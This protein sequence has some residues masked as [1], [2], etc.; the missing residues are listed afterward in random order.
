MSTKVYLVGDKDAPAK[1]QWQAMT[2]NWA[3]AERL[4]RELGP[5]ATHKVVMVEESRRGNR[6]R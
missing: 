2:N 3:E 1:N 6:K 4:K 5:D